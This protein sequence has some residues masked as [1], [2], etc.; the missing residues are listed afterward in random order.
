[1]CIIVLGYKMHPQHD[2]IVAANRDE[3]YKRPTKEMEQWEDAPHIWAGR[4]LE[5]MGTWLAVSDNGRFAAVTN[6]RDPRLPLV[7]EKSRGAVPVDF[8]NSSLN[9]LQFTKQLQEER[10]LYGAFNVVLYDEEN[11]VYYNT[12]MNELTIIPPGIHCI[13]NATL[14]TPWP[15]VKRLK[16]AFHETIQTTTEEEALFAILK[17]TIRADN[18]DLPATGVPF[19]VEQKL[20][21]IFIHFD[22]YGTRAST[23]VKS[24]DK[25]WDIAERSFT[26]GQRARDVRFILVQHTKRTEN[27][28][29]HR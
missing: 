18:Q 10:H 8:I 29:P 20:S 2:L 1:M 28:L 3:F 24:T 13:S 23:I 17:D 12:V 25:G 15:K 4:D 5:K 16:A 27:S 7:G 26:N 22:G 9:A 6:Y 14:N 21:S 19:E 11:L